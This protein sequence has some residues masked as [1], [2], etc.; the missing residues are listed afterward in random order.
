MK[1]IAC[2]LSFC[3]VLMFCSTRATAQQQ[4]EAAAKSTF[5]VIYRPG[6]AWLPGKPVSEQPLKEH[7]RYMLSLYVKGSLKLAGPLGTDAGGAVMLEVADESEARAIVAEDPAVKS[8]IFVHEI[9]PW[10]VV[11]WE[12]Y[13]KKPAPQA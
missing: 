10:R 4:Q 1:A 3:L 13:V 11:Q 5:L 9:H 2:S 8:G 7:G 12:K 6:P